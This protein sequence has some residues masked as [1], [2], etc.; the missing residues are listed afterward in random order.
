MDVAASPFVQTK[1]LTVID[2]SEGMVELELIWKL[3]APLTVDLVK[4]GTVLGLEAAEEIAVSFVS[5]TRP[6]TIQPGL[7][8]FHLK[9][10]RV[11]GGRE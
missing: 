10:D 2:A 3:P 4:L 6:V 1:N 11:S 9:S 8:Q 7:N 5:P